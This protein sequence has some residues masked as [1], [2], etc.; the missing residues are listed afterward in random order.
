MAPGQLLNRGRYRSDPPNGLTGRV[1]HYLCHFSGC[2]TGGDGAILLNFGEKM[3]RGIY[4]FNGGNLEPVGDLRGPNGEVFREA[5]INHNH[6]PVTGDEPIVIGLPGQG[7]TR[8]P[9]G[10]FFD[11]VGEM[12]YVMVKI[13]E[14]Y[15]V[16]QWGEI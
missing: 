10:H 3:R 15:G 9:L 13:I 1:A 2:C 6:E 7:A 16:G 11:P 14:P 4:D 12:G 5:A 8:M